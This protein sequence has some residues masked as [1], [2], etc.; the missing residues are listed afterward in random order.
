M[1]C[2][3][4][5]LC[6]AVGLVVNWCLRAFASSLVALALPVVDRVEA[7]WLARADTHA[8]HG[9]V[10]IGRVLYTCNWRLHKNCIVMIL[11]EVTLNCIINGFKQM[12]KKKRLTFNPLG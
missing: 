9:H 11:F 5:S 1:S 3:K 8:I 6:C 4:W 12:G 10:N 2:G 7:T